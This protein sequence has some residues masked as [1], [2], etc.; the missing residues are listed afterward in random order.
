MAYLEAVLHSAGLAMALYAVPLAMVIVGAAL[1]HNRPDPSAWAMYISAILVFSV[2]IWIAAAKYATGPTPGPA[3]FRIVT[4]F[5]AAALLL[6]P[7]A[8]LMQGLPAKVSLRARARAAALIG[9]A[10]AILAAPALLLTV[11]CILTGECL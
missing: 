10:L 2:I 1:A 8:A 4:T 11:G 7:P 5:I 6:A 3:W 9:S